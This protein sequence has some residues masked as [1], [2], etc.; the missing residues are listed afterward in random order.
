VLL[1]AGDAVVHLGPWQGERRG[2]PAA[3]DVRLSFLTAG[4]LYFGEGPFEALDADPLGG[5]ILAAATA[6]MTEIVELGTPAPPG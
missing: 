1:S 3:G 2:P 4:G 5:P 6:V